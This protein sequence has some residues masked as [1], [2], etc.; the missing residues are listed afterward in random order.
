MSSIGGSKVIQHWNKPDDKNN[1][2]EARKS[3]QV[4]ALTLS[5]IFF[6]DAG[7]ESFTRLPLEHNKGRPSRRPTDLAALGHPTHHA[8]I[9]ESRRTAGSDGERSR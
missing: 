2:K 1:A 6:L 9:E 4:Y 5:P 7:V 3:G 8:A